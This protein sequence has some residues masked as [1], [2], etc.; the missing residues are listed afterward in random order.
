MAKKVDMAAAVFGGGAR[1]RFPAEADLKSDAWFVERA[2]GA[3]VA[4]DLSKRAALDLAAS[5]NRGES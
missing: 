4:R 3:V 1:V 5:V 2:D